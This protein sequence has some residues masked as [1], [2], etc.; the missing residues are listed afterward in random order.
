[1]SRVS[2][3][4][5]S[6]RRRG[7]RA[8]L[9]LA[10]SE[11]R[12]RSRVPL[13]CL[14]ETWFDLR[15]GVATRGVVKH[16]SRAGSYAHAEVY[17][18]VSTPT[19][20]RAMLDPRVPRGPGFVFLDLGCGKGKALLLASSYGFKRVIGLEL[21]GEL[22]AA[23]RLN[24]E[25][26]SRT[27]PTLPSIEIVCGD[28]M[29]YDPPNEPLLIY[30]HNPFDAVALE[31]VAYRLHRSVTSNPRPAFILYHTPLHREVLDRLQFLREE[32]LVYGGVL[33]AL[34]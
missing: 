30:L 29:A 23:A 14:S 7:L 6:L 25:R 20:H 9:S 28:A 13:R 32:G 24:V 17:Q 26:F 2:R 22:A 10:A 27:R 3:V 21:S 19:F 12:R 8:T 34:T 16:Q 15:H 4:R 11:S 18:G 1:M 31:R 33:Y 5:A